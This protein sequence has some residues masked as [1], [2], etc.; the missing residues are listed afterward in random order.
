MIIIN[1]KQEFIDNYYYKGYKPEKY[2]KKYPCILIH[3]DCGGGL[4]GEYV[5]HKFVY[6]PKGCDKKSFMLGLKYSN[7]E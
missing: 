6:F 1:N 2:P 3:E 4:M 5:N 7:E